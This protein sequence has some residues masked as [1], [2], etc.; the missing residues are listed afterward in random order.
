MARIPA[1]ALKPSAHRNTPGTAA[2]EYGRGTGVPHPVDIH[3][4]ARIRQRR[5]LLGMNQQ[6]LADGLG[7]SFQQVQKYEHGAN[8]VSASCLVAIAE[9]LGVSVAY[10]FLD[11][12]AN[13]GTPSAEEKQS[14]ERMRQPETIDLVRF[15]YGIPDERVRGEF[16]NLV[17]AIAA[18]Q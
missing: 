17:K 6:A 1:G 3:V 16:L 18:S 8:R 10:F 7:L 11:L 4:G 9:I 12:E 15:Y 14:R 5:L 13:E 2:R